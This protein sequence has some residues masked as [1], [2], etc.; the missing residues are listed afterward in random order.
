MNIVEVWFG[1]IDRQA[2]KRGV[3]TSVKNLNKKIR[4]VITGWNKRK[5]LFVWTKTPE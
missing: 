3:F 2:I 5:H 4:G 1:S